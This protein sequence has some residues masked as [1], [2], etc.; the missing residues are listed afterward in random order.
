MCGSKEARFL[1]GTSMLVLLLSV[2]PSLPQAGGS[3]GRGADEAWIE[4]V[5]DNGFLFSGAVTSGSGTEEDPYIMD[6]I[7]LKNGD[8]DGMVI[9]STTKHFIVSNCTVSGDGS[10]TGIV[11]RSVRNGTLTTCSFS[12]RTIA[13][14]I[15]D[16]FDITIDRSTIK[17]CGVT[18]DKTTRFSMVGS[19]ADDLGLQIWSSSG[20]CI[21]GNTMVSGGASIFSID[22]MSISG[23]GFASIFD[24]SFCSNMTMEKNT[25]DGAVSL[26]R[27]DHCIM[28]SNRF[29]SS[30]KMDRCGSNHLSQN[31]HVGPGPSGIAMT[32]SNLNVIVSGSV[33][34]FDCGISM[35]GGRR[36]E[37]RSCHLT[38]NGLGLSLI[39]C[40]GNSIMDNMFENGL[41][42]KNDASGQ[43]WCD[44][45]ERKQNVLGGPW[46][47][48]NYWNDYNGTDLDHDGIGDTDTPYGP[49]DAFPL[50]KC[51]QKILIE[52][53]TLRNAKWGSEHLLTFSVA[54]P[55]TWTALNWEI[56]TIY[57]GED[58]EVI[59]NERIDGSN[60]T[61]NGLVERTV[62]IP[63]NTR[64][65]DYSIKVTDIFGNMDSFQDTMDVIQ[66][67]S[68]T[69]TIET[70]ALRRDSEVYVSV[71]ITG[72]A[73][74]TLSAMIAYD[75]LSDQRP[76]SVKRVDEMNWTIWF[77]IGPYD[78]I[79]I[80]LT[81]RDMDKAETQ[82]HLG[83][84]ETGTDT[85]ALG[86]M[87]ILSSPEA[88]RGGTYLFSFKVEGPQFL[89]L[90]VSAIIGQR[91]YPMVHL[92][93]E[94]YFHSS[95]Y[96]GKLAPDAA[97][98]I[99]AIEDTQ[100]VAY[101]D[102]KLEL[103]YLDYDDLVRFPPIAP[104]TG[105]PVS[106]GLSY[107]DSSLKVLSMRYVFDDDLLMDMEDMNN[108]VQVPIDAGELTISARIQDEQGSIAELSRT[109]AVTDSIPPRIILRTST[110]ENGGSMKIE[111]N[112]SDNIGIA[113]MVIRYSL[114]DGALRDVLLTDG[115]GKIFINVNA[116]L[117][118][119]RCLCSDDARHVSYQN[120]TLPIRDGIDPEIADVEFSMEGNELSVS[121]DVRDNRDLT[122]VTCRAWC[123]DWDMEIPMNGEGVHHT[124]DLTL[125]DNSGF[126][127]Y[128]AALDASGNAFKS[129]EIEVG[130]RKEGNGPLI[131]ILIGCILL[132]AIA[133][134]LTFILLRKKVEP[135]NDATLVRPHQDDI[136][137]LDPEFVQPSPIE[138]PI[139]EQIYIRPKN[140]LEKI[141]RTD[142]DPIEFEIRSGPLS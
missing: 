42:V 62:I 40:S 34:G 25:F 54:A 138:V 29:G 11:L 10:G 57:W 15:D 33:T 65:M 110:P 115:L 107:I 141:V 106:I 17:D 93:G 44:E 46:S 126:L 82:R 80:I 8:N 41:N 31:E 49:G 119:L 35:K 108:V 97:I 96:I 95:A 131:A 133:V 55:Y 26:Y 23:N 48:G 102:F 113:S 70:G 2:L 124:A 53:L 91:T 6:G 127:F 104:E 84:F 122:N 64:S 43:Y 5:G 140:R 103:G 13:L 12:D 132:S 51:K 67:D 61:S 120:L 71:R 100:N 75:D 77:E 58:G 21:E 73:V 37:V 72:G 74:N 135:K 28:D 142:K 19:S 66:P 99:T 56:S 32:D 38:E 125:P 118:K 139:P 7:S 121:A 114:D 137:V 117:I 123:K 69:V 112:C 4:I 89:K 87:T 130:E 86:R 90:E 47:G 79:M 94:G 39:S 27:T 129:T 111:A 109:I 136:M 60:L 20:G 101:H 63:E 18:I 50:V 85:K 36:N 22:H 76:G 128:I 98:R 1:F 105:S 14:D 16:S 116:N 30:L 88:K 3:P 68:F 59:G 134:V 52:D 83:W 78:R 24:T 81:I 45:P 92:G 9:R